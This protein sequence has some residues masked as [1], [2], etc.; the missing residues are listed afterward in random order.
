MPLDPYLAKAMLDWCLN[1]ATPTRPAGCWI[2]WATGSPNTAGS[3][4][5]PFSV[6]GVGARKTC[7]F[8]AANSPQGSCTNVAAISGGTATAIA[9]VLGWNLWDASAAGHRLMFGTMTLSVGNASADIMGANAGGLV[10]TLK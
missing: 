9:T 7:T 3:S 6:N 10:I 4:D 1:G 2:T 8:A 5:G